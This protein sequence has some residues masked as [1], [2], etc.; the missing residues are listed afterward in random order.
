MPQKMTYLEATP[1]IDHDHPTI[2]KHIGPFLRLDSKEEII[3]EVYLKVRD[4][5]RYD[6]YQISFQKEHFKASAIASRTSGHCIDKAIL[7]VTFLRALGIPARLHL[8]KVTNHIAV[9]RIIEKIGSHE[10]APHGMVGVYHNGKWV[11]ASPTFNKE[12]CERFHVPALEFDGNSDALLQAFNADGDTF[13]E[14]LEDYGHFEDVPF[15]FILDTFRSH[16]PALYEV[17]KAEGQIRL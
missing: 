9:E 15:D 6:P 7:M 14:Y 16:Y 11:K 10:L 13:M 2:R 17:F 4:G 8:A 3:R 1:Y 12:L 5:W